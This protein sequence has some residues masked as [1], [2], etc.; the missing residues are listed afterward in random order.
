MPEPTFHLFAEAPEGARA[1]LLARIEARDI[2]VAG[3]LDHQELYLEVHDEA[4]ALIGGLAGGTYWGW[5]YV[6]LL[7]VDPALRGR[8]WGAKLLAAAEAEAV[9]RGCRHAYL[10]TFSFQAPGFYERLGWKLAGRIDAIPA[11]SE[12]YRS[13]FEK[14][15]LTGP[16]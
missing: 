15:D 6:S 16:A 12:H 8:G 13:Y 9:R 11:G 3:P 14:R 7:W 4:G 10:D 5:L 2:E 1:A